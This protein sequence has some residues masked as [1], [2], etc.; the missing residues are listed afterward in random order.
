MSSGRQASTPKRLKSRWLDWYCFVYRHSKIK[1]KVASLR[2]GAKRLSMYKF[3]VAFFQPPPLTSKYVFTLMLRYDVRFL[4][5]GKIIECSFLIV[6]SLRHIQL[7]SCV[8]CI[9]S[10]LVSVQLWW[11]QNRCQCGTEVWLCTHCISHCTISD[12]RL[13]ASGEINLSLYHAKELT[14]TLLST[15]IPKLTIAPAM[16]CLL[17]E[18]FPTVPWPAAK[19]STPLCS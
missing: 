18:A 11:L 13:L 15:L 3:L 12:P 5:N 17:H 4:R 1:Y 2:T 6:P 8:L 9:I 14:R 10:K 7:S 19:W 16:L